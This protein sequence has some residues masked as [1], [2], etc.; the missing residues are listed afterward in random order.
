MFGAVVGRWRAAFSLGRPCELS[1]SPH[2]R[3][4]FP[5]QPQIALNWMYPGTYSWG[6]RQQEV[7]WR[8]ALPPCPLVHPY[9]PVRTRLN[10]IFCISPPCQTLRYLLSLCTCYSLCLRHSSPLPL[11]LHMGSLISMLPFQRSHCPSKFKVAAHFLCSLI[12]YLV[13]ERKRTS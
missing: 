13:F 6:E 11:S 9:I 2:S 8:W 7:G 3:N 5:I 10:E 1:R 12:S 4:H